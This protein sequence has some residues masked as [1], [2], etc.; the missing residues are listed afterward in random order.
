MINDL[1]KEWGVIL[2]E[3]G[4]SG[5]WLILDGLNLFLVVKR[6]FEEY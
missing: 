5:L 3:W 1:E 2:F 6:L 4:W